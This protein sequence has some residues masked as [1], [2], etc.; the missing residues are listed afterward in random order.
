[1]NVSRAAWKP[2]EVLTDPE[3]VNA[4]I[5]AKHLVFGESREEREVLVD[6]EHAALAKGLAGHQFEPLF[7]ASIA[8]LEAVGLGKTP[9]QLYLSY[10]SKMP[11]NLQRR[12]GQTS[13]C[14]RLTRRQS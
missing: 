13:G 12:L 10:L 8:E 6:G 9:R 2:G 5:K 7:E 14:G 11:P 1:M 4:R 3:A